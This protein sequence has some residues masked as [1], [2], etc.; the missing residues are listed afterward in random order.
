MKYVLNILLIL[1]STCSHSQDYD[2]LVLTEMHYGEVVSGREYVINVKSGRLFLTKQFY[3]LPGKNINHDFF[4]DLDNKWDLYSNKVAFMKAI[5]DSIISSGIFSKN[6]IKNFFYQRTLNKYFSKNSNDTTLIGMVESSTINKLFEFSAKIANSKPDTLI[7]EQIKNST[8]FC[9]NKKNL[10]PQMLYS[11]FT[12]ENR[13]YSRFRIKYIK[14]EKEIWE[15]KSAGNSIYVVPWIME[16]KVL[17]DTTLNNIWNKMVP[18]PYPLYVADLEKT[19]YNRLEN[20]FINACN[21]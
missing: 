10:I 16:D 5:D 14:N 12:T 2:Y 20:Y 7:C 9:E 19:N 13:I 17:F 8:K 11:F 21:Y 3:T 18:E 4:I 1:F 15:V 6:T